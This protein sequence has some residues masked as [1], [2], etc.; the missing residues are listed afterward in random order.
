[1]KI[2]Q[3]IRLILVLSISAC[4]NRPSTANIPASFETGK[5]IDTVICK[6]DTTQ[7][8]ALYIPAKGNKEA[9]PVI[10][11][12]DPHA[13]GRLPLNKYK[14]LADTYGYI[15]VGSNNSK[16]GNDWSATENIWN[17]LSADVQSRLKIDS[18]RIY[19]GGFS[20]GAKV[21]GYI[22]LKYPVIK[23][24]IA[25]GAGLPDGTSPANFNFSYT[26]IAGEGDLNLTDIVA[27]SKALVSTQTRQHLILFDGK[28]EWAPDSTM[29]IAFAGLQL[30][31]M[32]KKIIPEN[33]KFIND[34]IENSKERLD[35]F[36]NAKKLIKA[37]EEC[38]LSISFL[39]GLT[40]K[41][42]WFHENMTS[43]TNDPLYKTQ[44]RIQEQLLSIE[45]NT[46]NDYAR[47]FEQAD[48]PYWVKTIGYL[49]T[50]ATTQATESPMYQRLLAYLSLAFYSYSNH[51][52]TANANPEARYFVELYKLADATNSEAW[53][54]S[55]IL[56]AREGKIDS[57]EK[58]LLKAV[59]NGFRDKTRMKLQ[60][61]FQGIQDLT[62]IENK[63][64]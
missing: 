21:A 17:N 26:A 28:H 57:T 7:S 59:E 62:S 44:D 46:K 27:F 63:M 15:L 41:A 42:T 45:Q 29:N 8:Y 60:S 37:V 52:I 3:L 50:R 49:K 54:F 53:Y 64:N 48:M 24:V 6:N 23:G 1:M 30:D 34:Y 5:V 38:T 10:Y 35:T 47:H 36:Y 2:N 22:A 32:Q 4:V 13:D 16:N 61:E 14:V 25:N 39:D 51:F 31:A 33:D 9:L 40:D 19:T 20:G 18:N 58:D 12:F 11:L 55:A 56:D 43:L